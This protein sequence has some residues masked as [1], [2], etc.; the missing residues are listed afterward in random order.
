MEGNKHAVQ[1]LGIEILLHYYTTP[2]DYPN[3]EA[4]AVIELIAEFVNKGLLIKEGPKAEQEPG[5][6]FKSSKFDLNLVPDFNKGRKY[7]ANREALEVYINAICSVPL[8]VNVW[9]MPTEEEPLKALSYC[10]VC[11]RELTNYNL[12]EIQDHE[13]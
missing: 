8:P 9:R 10:G 11:S 7:R 3:M 6:G 5:N 13:Q 1:P 2:G 4:P 12:K